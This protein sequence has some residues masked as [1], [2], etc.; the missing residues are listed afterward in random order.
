MIYLFCNEAYGA[1]FV[2]AAASASRELALPLRL[3]FSTRGL[4][5]PRPDG[6]VGGL[7]WRLSHA[8]RAAALSRRHGLPALLAADVNTDEF[9]ARLATDAHGI[10]TGFNQIFRRATIERFR[11]LVNFHPSLLPYYRGPVP[12]TW[13]LRH[14]ERSSG[15]TLH[16]V[17]ERIDDG[18]IL[19]QE[20]V[21]TDGVPTAEA[22]DRRIAEAGAPTLRCW[23]EHLRS[24]SPF[25]RLQL[26]A[27]AIYREHP[28]YLSFDRAR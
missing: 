24:G 10:I 17:T 3:V 8:R 27:A 26:D 13:C 22:L 15:Y 2:E 11:T 5:P 25:P 9:H 7:R 20:A 6:L 1:P 21:P 12:S 19:Y 23:L 14:G 18:E 16:R 4:E 28:D